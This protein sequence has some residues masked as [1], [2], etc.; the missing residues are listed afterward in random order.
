MKTS[1]AIFL[2]EAIGD[3]RLQVRSKQFVQQGTALF[4]HRAY[5]HYMS[6][7]QGRERR[8][9]LFSTDPLNK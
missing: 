8:W 7:E 6:T 3:Q 5:W 2:Y 9:R 4:A 1:I